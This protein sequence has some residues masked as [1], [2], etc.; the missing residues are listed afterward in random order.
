MPTA[1]TQLLGALNFELFGQLNNV[2]TD[3]CDWFDWQLRSM[4]AYVG[5]TDGA[6][7]GMSA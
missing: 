4:A 5:L 2:I 7:E 6:S 1:W 3:P